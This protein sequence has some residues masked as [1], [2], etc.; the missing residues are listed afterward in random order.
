MLDDVLVLLRDEVNR[1]LSASLGVESAQ[2]DQG[3]VAFVGT[4]SPET[5]DFKQGSVSLLLVNVE[6]EFSLRTGD[7]YRTVLADGT[8]QRVQPPIQLNLLVLFAARFKDYQQALRSLSMVL[9]FFHSHRVLDHNS[10]PSL[11]ARIEKV[12]MD[13]MTLSLPE[14]QNLWAMLKAPY[15]PSLLYKARMVV[16]HDQEA[17]ATAAP[18]SEQVQRFRR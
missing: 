14:Q 16:Y 15:Q 4:D 13:L 1:Y 8:A 7:P 5:L 12:M 2:T 3:Q 11:S 6:Q 9:Q 10:A 18:G 17:T